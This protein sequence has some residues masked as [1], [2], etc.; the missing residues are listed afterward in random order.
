MIRSGNIVS[1]KVLLLNENVAFDIFF[2]L[3][4][5]SSVLFVIVAS[6][7][8]VVFAVLFEFEVIVELL[9]E[10]LAHFNFLILKFSLLLNKFVIDFSSKLSSLP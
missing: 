9:I 2:K 5:S 8:V 1:G 10:P 6:V 3:F 7:Q 4:F